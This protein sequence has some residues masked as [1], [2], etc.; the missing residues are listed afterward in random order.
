MPQ[1]NKGELVST[2]VT[3]SRRGAISTRL[4]VPTK[5][6]APFACSRSPTGHKES[7]RNG[8]ELALSVPK[9]MSKSQFEMKK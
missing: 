8:F 2:V 7:R 5:V 3:E 1:H 9:G 6:G 4:G